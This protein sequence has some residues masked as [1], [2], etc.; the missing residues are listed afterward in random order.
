MRG[1]VIGASICGSKLSNIVKRLGVPKST[2]QDWIE[3]GST[4]AKHRS[5]R[6]TKLS[7]R[8]LR[9]LKR[10]I[11]TDRNTR[12]MSALQILKTLEFSITERTLITALTGLSSNCTKAAISQRYRPRTAS[13]ICIKISTLDCGRLEKNYMDR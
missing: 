8:D 4:I 12:R 7:P 3:S 6:P 1:K 9:Q 13:G 2:C 11:Q 5:G 10:F